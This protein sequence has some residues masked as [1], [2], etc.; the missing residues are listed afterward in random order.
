VFAFGV[1]FDV[2]T[3]L[4]DRLSAATRGTTQYVRPGEDVEQV[5]GLLATRLRHP[6]LTDLVLEGGAA[7]I[8]EVYPRE[9]PDLFAGDELVLFG[10]YR[11]AGGTS[12]AVR[13]SRA[14]RAERFTT[15]VRLPARSP[16]DE[17]IARLW[18][19]RK[20]GDLD[21]RIRSAQADGAGAQQVAA[22][23][24]DLRETA[25]RYGLLSE[26]TSYLV[27]EP[28]MMADASGRVMNQAMPLAPPPAA[29]SG[30]GA[31]A[32]AEEARRSREV[33][34]LAQMESVQMQA[35]DRVVVTAADGEAS[36]GG[37]RT[38]AGRTFRLRAGV[39]TDTRHPDRQQIME[40]AAYSDAYFALI[41]QLPETGLVLRELDH[42]LIAGRAVS[43]R[44]TDKGLKTLPDAQLRK[45][46]ADFR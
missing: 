33:S 24:E 8:T 23:I 10:R 35:K 19:S 6:V 13:G 46:V 18:A 29:V 14:G 4:L 44:V 37:M 11:R 17:Y 36:A 42:A 32:R 16:G 1:G 31:V 38:V 26:Y 22:M 15:Q 20:L 45:L 21:R 2:N 41:R 43:V 12:I 25:L 39:W 5:V 9:L 40:I 27:Q 34:S 3:Y 7:D 30:Q 28:G